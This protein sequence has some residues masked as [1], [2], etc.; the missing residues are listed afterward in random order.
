ME[1]MYASGKTSDRSVGQHASDSGIV[2]GWDGSTGTGSGS[3]L[4]GDGIV[5]AA[6]DRVY[7][8]MG[9]FVWTELAKLQ[10]EKCGDLNTVPNPH[11]APNAFTYGPSFFTK[12]SQ[13]SGDV[14]PGLNR[15]LNNE[16]NTLGR[17]SKPPKQ[18]R[19]LFLSSWATS[20]NV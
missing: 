3:C 11:S 14:T 2:S 16:A 7:A 4:R 9:Y 13:L 20:Q 10:Q 12:A 19:T 1:G 6:W 8:V 18:C 5:E 17:S 15:R